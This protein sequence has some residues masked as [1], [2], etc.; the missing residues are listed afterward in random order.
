MRG[1]YIGFSFNGYHSDDL[2]IV[3]VSDGDRY[4]EELLPEFEDATVDVPGGDGTYYFG[5]YYK[6]KNFTINVAF[7]FLTEKQYRSLIR[8]FSTRAPAPLIFDE[9]P[10][11]A[12]T[13]KVE[14]P[15]SFKVVCFDDYIDYTEGYNLGVAS[16][17]DDYSESG[18][19]DP[20]L[21]GN[22]PEIVKEKV[23]TYRGEGEITFVAYEPFA[24][25]PF[26]TLAEYREYYS[27]V[28]EWA[29]ASGMLESLIIA[30]IP[31][32]A[33]RT[34]SGRTDI[35]TVA[36]IG[37]Y[38]MYLADADKI[39]V[40]NPGDLDTPFRLYIPFN[41]DVINSFI[42]SLSDSRTNEA[43][44]YA[45]LKIDNIVKL[46]ATDTGILINTKN[47]LIEGVVKNES[48]Y[49]TTG[50][51]YNQFVKSG[52]FFKIPCGNGLDVFDG[53]IQF[54]YNFPVVPEIT[55]NYIYF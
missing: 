21:E 55:Y 28:D 19:H 5:S 18:E 52:N 43:I 49:T 27:N 2:G 30:N 46:N 7:D 17:L 35:N 1:D 42:I 8:L 10:Y 50:T 41:G 22:R 25:A 6:K 11:K 44:E 15:P 38:D 51:I 36:D 24:Y 31:D 16:L 40:Y 37:Q 39:R 48:S 14:A 9:R 20:Y 54:P 13:V 32:N 12:Y 26:K 45:A 4:D 33:A 53:Y 47:Q 3:R 23:R 34:E 29:E